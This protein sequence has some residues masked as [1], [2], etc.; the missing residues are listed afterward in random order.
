MSEELPDYDHRRLGR[1]LNLFHVQEEA[2]GSVFWHPRGYALFRAV[3][4]YIR[5]RLRVDGYEEVRTPQVVSSVLWKQSGHWDK[6]RKNMFLATDAEPNPEGTEGE[7]VLGVK[8]MNCP[9]HVQI[10]NANTVSYRD[11]PMRMAEFGICHRNEP[12]GALHGIMRVRQF[13]QD[14]AHIFCTEDQIA[15]ET[16]RFCDL[17]MSVYQ[18]FGF[19]EIGI[20]LSTRPELRAGSDEQWD[21]AESA[22]AE[23]V[24]AAGLNATIQPGE[25]AFYGPKLEFALTDLRGRKW[26]CGTLQLDFVLPQNLNALFTDSD[27]QRKHPVMLHRAI[28]GSLERFIGILLEQHSGRLPSWLAPV[29]YAVMPLKPEQTEYAES[30]H[31]ELARHG[32]RG[33]VD[34]RDDNLNNKVRDHLEHKVPY[35]IVVGPRDQTNGAMSVRVNG[36]KPEVLSFGE[37]IRA[38][39]RAALRPT[40]ET[41]AL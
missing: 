18:D 12:S 40:L 27:G 19:T 22:L 20:G 31:A 25:G 9:C 23:A 26:Q 10:F 3:E 8:P 36:E 41:A 13:T 30:I 35:V 33:V 4:T 21:K 5:D 37:G 6:F 15:S 7:H 28:L 34:L 2:A 29:Q 32:V 24:E 17:L 38:I 11:L 16:K 39:H 14:D 1:E